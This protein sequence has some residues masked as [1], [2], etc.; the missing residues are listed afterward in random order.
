MTGL[1]QILYRERLFMHCITPISQ[2]MQNGIARNT[3]Q[4]GTIDRCSINL[5]CNFKHYIHGAYFFHIFALYTIQPQ[6]LCA[7]LLF[8]FYLTED[9]SCIVAA[10][11]CKT[12]TTLNSAHQFIFNQNLNGIHT[13]F[14][15]CTTGA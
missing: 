6:H 1:H 5:T 11:F 8:C 2:N 10:A 14:I 15:I 13:F 12:G 4:Y 3:G 9:R 7:P